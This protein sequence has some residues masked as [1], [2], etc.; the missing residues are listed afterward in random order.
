MRALAAVHG[1][2]ILHRDISPDN[3]YVTS[4]GVK[5]IDFGAARNAL[6]QKSRNLSIILKEGFAPEEQYRSSG[7]QGPWT[8][9]YATAGT[10]YFALTGKIPQGA[11]DRQVEDKLEYPSRLGSDID[12]RSEAALMR[13]LS[14]RAHDRFQSMQDF[15]AALTGM[16][17]EESP[18]PYAQTMQQAPPQY[19]PPYEFLPPAPAAPAPSSGGGKWLWIAI[20]VVAVL[21]LAFLFNKPT[22]TPAPGPTGATGASGPG[23]A[24]TQP[25]GDYKGLIQQAGALDQKHAY[26]DE[27]ALLDRAIKL[28]PNRF[29]A[30]DL[31]AQIYLYNFQQWPEAKDNFEKSLAHG[32]N[33]TFHVLHD[34]G[35]GIF[36]SS[37][38]GWLYV[39]RNSLEYKASDGSPHKFNVQRSEITDV[40]S[41]KPFGASADHHALHVRVNKVLWN[42][43]P[44]GQF[45]DEQRAMI[46][47]I[48]GG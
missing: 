2:G 36:S 38:H 18:Q 13:A 27:L 45:G 34:H 26:G 43:A 15:S 7:T 29:E 35:G 8:D 4:S 46:L 9:V 16:A 28:D 3:I 32:G 10:L 44:Q 30:Y 24:A 41:L 42:F 33:A 12:P 14:I 31:K 11:L 39:T 21:I 17:F 20:G 19:A 47:S 23:P 5:L 22:P 40:G 37:C 1:E 25:S 6:G 48:I